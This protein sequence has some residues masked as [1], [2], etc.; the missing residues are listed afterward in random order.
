MWVYNKELSD[1]GFNSLPASKYYDNYTTTTARSGGIC[2]EHALSETNS[3]S[4]W[5]VSTE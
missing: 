3:H 5:V 4:F 1:S 2:Y